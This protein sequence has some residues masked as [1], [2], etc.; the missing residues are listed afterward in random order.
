MIG[1]E[2]C[3]EEDYMLII[4]RRKRQ[5]MESLKQPHQK[6]SVTFVEKENCKYFCIVEA[7]SIKR[8]EIKET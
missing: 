5:I 4:K 8:I 7:Y 2:F 3:I 6:S 1:M